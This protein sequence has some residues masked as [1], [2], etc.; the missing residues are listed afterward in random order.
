MCYF[1]TCITYGM[2]K[3]SQ[4]NIQVFPIT[5]IFYFVETAPKTYS[6][7][8]FQ[9]C[10][11]AADC[12]YHMVNFFKLNLPSNRKFGFWSTILD[13]HSCTFQL[14]ILVSTFMRS[15]F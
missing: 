10:N 4:L 6:H 11:I 1:H 12:S 5:F 2:A 13:P 7:S 3:I 15:T 14:L 8:N 9:S